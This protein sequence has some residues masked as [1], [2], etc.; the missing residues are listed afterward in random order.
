[1]DYIVTKKPLSEVDTELFQLDNLVFNR[2]FDIPSKDV[3]E[4]SSF[5]KNS[6]IH[7][8]YNEKT[9]IAFCAY[10][11][12]GHDSTE[13]KVMAVLPE[14]QNKGIGKAM[15]KKMLEENKGK[16]LFLVTHP[17]NTNAITFYFKHGFEIVGW[18]ENYFGDGQPRLVM[19]RPRVN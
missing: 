15:M 19:R 1:M 4:E 17:S 18:R 16:D 2:I 13:V 9:P 10:E 5:L 3:E 11:P 14:F 7:L 6:T 8:V 12:K